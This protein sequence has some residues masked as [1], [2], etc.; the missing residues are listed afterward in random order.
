MLEKYPEWEGEIRTVATLLQGVYNLTT[1]IFEGWDKIFGLFREEGADAMN[2]A[3][4]DKGL[5]FLTKELGITDEQSGPV[6]DWLRDKGLGFLTREIG[7]FPSG[8]FDTPLTSQ[9]IDNTSLTSQTSAN[10]T[11]EKIEIVVNGS[12]QNPEDIAQSVY[13]V[14]SQQTSQDLNSTVDQ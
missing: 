2:Q 3:L 8:T 4:K 7:L 10:T 5:G 13:D 12:G 6:N 14:F 9:T 1:M 11:V